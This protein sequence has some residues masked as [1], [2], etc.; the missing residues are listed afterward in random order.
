MIRQTSLMAYNYV[1]KN[2]GER[3]KLVYRI[4]QANQPINDTQIAYFGYLFINQVTPRRLE[5]LKMG[6]IEEAF[7]AI[8]KGKN[9]AVTYWKIKNQGETINV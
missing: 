3:Q 5:L 9:R 4:I 7:V 2:L 8:P 6:L 1:K